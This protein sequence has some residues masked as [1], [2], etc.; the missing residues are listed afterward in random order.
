MLWEIIA[1]THHRF[2]LFISLA[3][4][5]RPWPYQNYWMPG[6]FTSEEVYLPAALG[7]LNTRAA[8]YTRGAPRLAAAALGGWTS[9]EEMFFGGG[10]GMLLAPNAPYRAGMAMAVAGGNT[11][12]SE[13]LM[14]MGGPSVSSS[15]PLSA[16]PF[17]APNFCEIPANILLLIILSCSSGLN[18]QESLGIC[19][20]CLIMQ[21]PY[22]HIVIGHKTVHV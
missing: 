18:F 13:E 1:N 5:F 22:F 7:A 15:V 9:S 17:W 21:L 2:S 11:Y 14:W 16:G 10:P 19:Y 20:F 4:P 12:S 6:G 8:A 3:R